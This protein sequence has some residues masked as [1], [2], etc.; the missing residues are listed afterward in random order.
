MERSAIA[1]NVRQFI[2]RIVGEVAPQ[3]TAAAE[4]YWVLATTGSDEAQERVR[5]LNEQ[6]MQRFANAEEWQQVRDWHEQRDTISDADT[7]RELEQLYLLYAGSQRTPE[8]ISRIATLETDLNALYTSFRGT[9]AGQELS[10][11]DIKDV[12]RNELDSEVRQA[13]WEA[14]KQI[15]ARASA[16]LLEL[17]RVRN[18]AAHALGWRDYY[19][20]ALALQEVDEQELFALLEELERETRAPFQALKAEFDAALSQRFGVPVKDLR[21]WHY[22]DPFFQEA[23][24]TG[25]VDLDQ[26]FADQDIEALTVATFDGIGLDVRDILARSDM[27]ERPGKDQ[28]AFCTHIDRATDDVRVLCN[29]RPSAYWMEVDLHEFGHA[30]YDKYLAPDLPYLLRS[31]AHINTTEAI[32]M[33]MGR[34]ARN[35]QWLRE[36]RG[37]PGVV[38]SAA[39]APARAEERTKQ[40]VFV[41]WALVMAFFE[42]A[43]YADP[44]RSDLNSLWWD[45]VERFQM[46][47]R[48]EY[49]DEPD[50]ATKVHLAT[51]PV[52]YHN[53]VLGE[54]TASQLSNAIVRDVPGGNLVGN[55][56][57]GAFLRDQLFAL[58]A[59]L[60]WNDALAEVTGE[61]LSPR[62]FVSEFV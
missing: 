29:S 61:R 3:W 41:R 27:Y 17:V 40:L 37:L 62:Y 10:E 60:P 15:G 43:L 57:A 9:V 51:A 45:F 20:Q 54:L 28:H 50:W 24:H 53:Y 5:V 58:G 7:R 21:P 1:Q 44:D 31:A 38:A 12:L 11:N 48:P 30:I 18:A 34:L 35:E 56:A 6:I 22:S 2:D 14:S 47:P 8:Q 19:A 23:P 46:V 33:L 55:P 13:A 59:R 4:A 16:P 36:V 42:R 26:Y 52:Y 39:A 49:R 25:E 32:A